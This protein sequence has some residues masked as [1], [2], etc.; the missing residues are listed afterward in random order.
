MKTYGGVG[1]QLHTLLNLGTRWICVVSFTPQELYPTE[2]IP[3]LPT[4]QEAGWAPGTVWTRWR[5]EE[6]PCAP[7]GSRTSVV[8]FVVQSLY[9]VSYTGTWPILRYYPSIYLDIEASALL[10][11]QSRN[12]IH[13]T[14]LGRRI[15][16][17]RN[18][19]S[20]AW[21]HSASHFQQTSI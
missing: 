12:L 5:K 3:S 4:S 8:Q 6:N 19:P 14:R 1:V 9:W 16:P 17:E 21:I 15:F 10:Q 13:W 7:A 2:R 18:F 20:C 11:N